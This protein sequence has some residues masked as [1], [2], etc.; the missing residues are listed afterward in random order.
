M[1]QSKLIQSLKQLWHADGQMLDLKARRFGFRIVVVSFAVLV[2]SVSVVTAALGVYVALSDLFGGAGAA[3]ILS[4][5][6]MLLAMILLAC[7]FHGP[8]ANQL[9]DAEQAHDQAVNLL[10]REIHQFDI[11]DSGPLVETLLPLITPVVSA[12]I[13]EGLR[14]HREM[15]PAT[16]I[17]TQE[18]VAP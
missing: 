2:A 3:A 4:V 9:R 8:Y 13:V 5:S 10:K 15:G 16:E 12:L 6:S 1:T 18:N 7:A 17:R 14:R 11:S